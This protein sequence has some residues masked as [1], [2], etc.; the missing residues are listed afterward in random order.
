MQ[1]MF[2]RSRPE[3]GSTTAGC[4]T[5]GAGLVFGCRGKS[6]QNQIWGPLKPTLLLLQDPNFS[7]G[8]VFF[9]LP[10]IQACELKNVVCEKVV[11]GNVICIFTPFY[12][13][14]KFGFSFRHGV[15]TFCKSP[16]KE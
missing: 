8:D 5:S 13:S 16:P 7:N 9:L 4:E 10:P 6:R 3:Q 15:Q 14:P 12:T 11:C 1:G 2:R